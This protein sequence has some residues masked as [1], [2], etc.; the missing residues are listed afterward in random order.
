VN[1]T[2]RNC[3]FTLAL[4][5]LVVSV[6]AAEGNFVA[7]GVAG[8]RGLHGHAILPPHAIFSNCGAGCTSYNTGS[9]YYVS[10]TA[11]SSGAGQT[12]AVGFSSATTI[13]FHHA[14]TPNTVYTANGGASSG[15]MSAYLLNGSA[16][17]GPTTLLAKLTQA[18]TIPD[19]P[20][21][22]VIRYSAKKSVTFQAGTTYFLCETEPVANVQLLWMLSN[23]DFTSPFWFQDSDSCTATGLSWLNAT[24]ATA[25][26][27]VVYMDK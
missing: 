6:A 11:L 1:K 27:F 9:G 2:L 17:S 14:A 13:K 4:S 16:S 3:L 25:P 26:A 23:S 7:G 10:G 8:V 22:K 15:A 24:G 20:A 18:G 12:L 21:I 19:Y 5:L